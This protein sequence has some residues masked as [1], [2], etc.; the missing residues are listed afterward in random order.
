MIDLLKYLWSKHEDLSSIP[1]TLLN[2]SI[3]HG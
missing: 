2:D 1:S 3:V